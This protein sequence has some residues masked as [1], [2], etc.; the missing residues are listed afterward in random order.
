MHN[1]YYSASINEFVAQGPSAVLGELA[2]SNPFALD[3]LQ[4]NAWLS[5]IELL[6]AHLARLASGWI[7]F[8]FSIPRMGKRAD[9]VLV[10]AGIVFVVEF[11]IGSGQFDLAATD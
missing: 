1:A 9:A 4:R 7:A 10:T 5:Q 8:E 3:P 2:K 6:Q 11:K